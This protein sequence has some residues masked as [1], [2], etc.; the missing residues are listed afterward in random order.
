VSG[1]PGSIAGSKEGDRSSDVLGF[2]DASE[3]IEVA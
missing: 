1:D 3:R 2:P